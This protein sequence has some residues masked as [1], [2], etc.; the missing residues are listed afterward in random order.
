[1]DNDDNTIYTI[2]ILTDKVILHITEIGNNYI[3]DT[4]KTKLDKRISNR[5]IADGYIKPDSIKIHTYSAGMVV[6]DKVEFHI[7]YEC[8]LCHPVV[9]MIL[10][11]KVNA[12]T[13]AG[14][15]AKVFDT[16]GNNPCVVFI[17]RENDNMSEYFLSV[18][19][20]D[21]IQAEVVGVRYELNDGYVA[22]IGTLKSPE[23]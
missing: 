17:L 12:I 5:C 13:K 7:V 2:S 15:H 6:F 23:R 1:M 22:V 9:G 14:I 18:K 16:N 21:I 10:T 4:L 8:K 3:E 20:N 19:E 11:C